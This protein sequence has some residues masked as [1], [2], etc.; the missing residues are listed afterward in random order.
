MSSLSLFKLRCVCPPISEKTLN[1]LAK[2]AKSMLLP[3]VASVA[4]LE[5]DEDG[6]E[7]SDKKKPV[8]L[9]SL[10]V[11]KKAINAIAKRV[12]WG[13]EDPAS[14][15][16]VSLDQKAANYHLP[17][18]LCL[19]RWE[20][21]DRT[22][23]VDGLPVELANKVEERYAERQKVQTRALELL[24]ALPESDRAAL[25][26]KT[27]KSK[28][29]SSSAAAAVSAGKAPMELDG[30]DNDSASKPEVVTQSKKGSKAKEPDPEVRHNRAL[31]TGLS[32]GR[33]PAEH[34]FVCAPF[35][36]KRRPRLNGRLKSSEKRRKRWRKPKSEPARLQKKL[37]RRQRKTKPRLSKTLPKP[38]KRP[39][40]RARRR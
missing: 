40:S 7:S 8:D 21:T 4:T 29:I 13:V 27:V 19:W 28:K 39:P 30:S 35:H 32:D 2:H 38:S 24:K 6:S 11:L 37:H 14:V 9:L 25:F 10:E 12:N 3:S 20:V 1:E 5:G 23:V 26:D 17:A 18:G 33:R 22:L 34:G 36:R 15:N 31:L 16:L